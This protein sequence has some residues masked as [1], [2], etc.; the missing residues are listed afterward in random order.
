MAYGLPG[1]PGYSYER[2]FDYFHFEL[3]AVASTGSGGDA[4]ENIMTRGLLYGT[5]YSVGDAYRGVWGLY[6]SYDYISPAIFRV[7]STALSVGTT[8]QW[9]LSH[10]GGAPGFGPRRR[11]FRRGRHHRP[12]GEPRRGYTR[13]PLRHRPQGLLALRLIFGRRPCS[14]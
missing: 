14:T 11:R 13:L 12:R 5:K 8:A 3:T 2:P 7:S 10:C 1:K 4:F 9:W 6:G